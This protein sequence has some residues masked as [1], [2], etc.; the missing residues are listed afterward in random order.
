MTIFRKF[1]YFIPGIPG[2]IILLW[3]FAIPEDLIKEKI[4]GAVLNAGSGNVSASMTGFRKGLFISLSADSLDLE[5]DRIPAL[6]IS[7]LTCRFDPGYLTQRRV[8]FSIGGRIGTGAVNGLLTY[9][10]EGEIKIDRAE[11]NS[12]PYLSHLGIKSNGYISADIRTENN[13]TKIA[14][15]IPDLAVQEASALFP[16]IDTFH[17]VQGV[18]SLAGDS[19]KVESISLEGEKGYAR[20]TGDIINR[21][22]DLKLELMPDA[23]KLTSLESMLIG[24]YQTAPGYYVIPVKGNFGQ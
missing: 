8:A 23:G 1:L 5:V 12:I 24:K 13:R 2:F 20:L 3:F 10:A 4:E 11:L 16:F 14:F 15:R 6:K 17:K 19:I 9:P 21:A 18:L 7:E 22:M